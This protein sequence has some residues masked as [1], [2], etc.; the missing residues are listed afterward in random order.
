[1]QVGVERFALG[2]D[3]RHAVAAQHAEQLRVDHLHSLGQ[4]SLVAG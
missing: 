2:V 1:M 3:A 4:R